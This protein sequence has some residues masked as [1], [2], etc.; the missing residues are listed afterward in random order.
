MGSKRIET[1]IVGGGQAGLATS[2]HLGRGGREHV[3]LEQAAQAGSAWRNDRWD[4]FTLVTPNWSFLLPGAEYHGDDLDGF[5]P[6]DEVVSRF[7]RY[8]ADFGLPVHHGVRVTSVEPN[9]GND[10]Y[11]VKTGDDVIEAANVVMAT[12]LFQR[13]PGTGSGLR[14]VGAPYITGDEERYVMTPT[15]TVVKVEGIGD[16][17]TSYVKAKYPDGSDWYIITISSY[18]DSLIVKRID[19]FAP[20]FDPPEWRAQWVE[21]V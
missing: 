20:F 17:L 8:V 19:F 18:K 7:G 3:V 10:G 9:A 4:S 2:N 14:L 13:L 21:V 11:L 1:V 6:R 12:G 16:E 15:F 5:M